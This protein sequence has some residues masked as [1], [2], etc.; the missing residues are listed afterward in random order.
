[1]LGKAIRLRCA[2][3]IF[4]WKNVNKMKVRSVAT[5]NFQTQL[6]HVYIPNLV[7][8][9][10][11]YVRVKQATTSNYTNA[12]YRNTSLLCLENKM[13]VKVKRSHENKTLWRTAAAA[14][15]QALPR[16]HFEMGNVYTTSSTWI[17]LI[18][19]WMRYADVRR[20]VGKWMVKKIKRQEESG[21]FTANKLKSIHNSRKQECEDARCFVRGA[22]HSARA[23]L[24]TIDLFHTR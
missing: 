15:C 10:S 4:F 5:T 16:Q 24:L 19:V 12:W 11:P 3:K 17:K 6:R 20:D 22:P 7:R 21:L 18:C 2:L 14:R 23:V 8:F 13:R 9:D 1:M